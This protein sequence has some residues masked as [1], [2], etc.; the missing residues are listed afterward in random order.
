MHVSGLAVLPSGVNP[1]AGVLVE[2]SADLVVSKSDSTDPVL[3]GEMLTYDVTIENNGPSA[4]VDVALTDTLPDEVSF[5]GYTI[6]NGSGT[7]VLLAGPPNAV[8]CDLDD[9]NP[10]Q[11]VT[12]FINV[13]VDLAVPNGTIITNTATVSSFLKRRARLVD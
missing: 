5:V 3:A 1:G 6:S 7:C 11:F 2:A 10:G 9:L 4:A 8:E 12:V 13:L